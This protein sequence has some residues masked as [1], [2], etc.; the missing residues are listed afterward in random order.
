MMTPFEKLRSLPDAASYLRP[1]VTMEKL[2]EM[3]MRMSDRESG[4]RVRRA[5]LRTFKPIDAS[6]R[7]TFSRAGA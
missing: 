4:E 1:G 2:H 7:K 6:V 3:Q 5:L